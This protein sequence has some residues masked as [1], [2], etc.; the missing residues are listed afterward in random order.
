MYVYLMKYK[1]KT[2]CPILEIQLFLERKFPTEILRYNL[3]ILILFD[4][5]KEDSQIDFPTGNV[6]LHVSSR[7]PSPPPPPP[8]A[9]KRSSL[10]I[11]NLK[12]KVIQI[13]QLN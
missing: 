9:E 11:D 7:P 13:F 4:A 5:V 6:F 8:P 12:A 3:L 2:R 10:K 1:I